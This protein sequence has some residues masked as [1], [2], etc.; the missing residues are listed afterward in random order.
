MSAIDELIKAYAHYSLTPSKAG[1]ADLSTKGRKVTRWRKKGQV[2]YGKETRVGRGSD[3]AVCAAL[4]A[5][6]IISAGEGRLSYQRAYSRVYYSDSARRYE[7]CV[8]AKYLLRRA[9]IMTKN[10]LMAIARAH[11]IFFHYAYAKAPH[12]DDCLKNDRVFLIVS[13]ELD[14]LHHDAATRV[15]KMLS[16]IKNGN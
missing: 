11:S 8:L 1:D 10:D 14:R 12:N 15:G 13:R 6:K 7:H 3:G 2:C 5:A 9:Q 4:M 16:V